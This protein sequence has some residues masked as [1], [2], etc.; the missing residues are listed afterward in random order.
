MCH[1]WHACGGE[2]LVYFVQEHATSS[3]VT[4]FF[5]PED[6][7]CPFFDNRVSWSARR[8]QGTDCQNSRLLLN[9]HGGSSQ[10]E[11]VKSV[12]WR[13]TYP[14]THRCVS[15]VEVPPKLFCLQ[16]RSLP[17][18]AVTRCLFCHFVG[19]GSRGPGRVSFQ[20]RIHGPAGWALS[21]CS[22]ANMYINVA[23][24]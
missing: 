17:K 5:V 23:L 9:L 15:S 7:G 4:I 11:Q 12:R 22:E 2:D 13:R 16:N 21:C 10:R 19:Q 18:Q 8:E 1:V 6:S 3:F 20:T 14:L 24:G